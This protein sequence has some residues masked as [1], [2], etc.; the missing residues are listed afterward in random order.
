[1]FNYFRQPAFWQYHV[2]RSCYSVHYAF[3]NLFIVFRSFFEF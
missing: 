2:V 1:M 3:V